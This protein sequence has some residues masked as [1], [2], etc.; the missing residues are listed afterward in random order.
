MCYTHLHST[1]S[2]AAKYLELKRFIIDQLSRKKLTRSKV[3]REAR[4]DPLIQALYFLSCGATTLI[5]VHLGAR[6]VI[7]LFICAAIPGNIVEPSLS[8][9]FANKYFLI[10]LS[11]LMIELLAFS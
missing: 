1:Y 2:L 11:Y 10:S 9:M 7:S 6:A 5:F 8:T 4:I 3:Q